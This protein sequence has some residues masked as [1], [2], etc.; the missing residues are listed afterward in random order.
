MLYRILLYLIKWWIRFF[1]LE[2]WFLL[3]K[4][5]VHFGTWKI[6]L[7]VEWRF[8]LLKLALNEFACNF[9]VQWAARNH[10]G[11]KFCPEVPATQHGPLYDT[12]P[13]LIGSFVSEDEQRSVVGRISCDEDKEHPVRWNCRRLPSQVPGHGGTSWIAVECWHVAGHLCSVCVCVEGRFH[14]VSCQQV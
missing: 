5:L 3:I 6:W 7:Y 14:S 12:A 1:F 13:L 10:N 11:V 4:F 8:P 2:N 9:S